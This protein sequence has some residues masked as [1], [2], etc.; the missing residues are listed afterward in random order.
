M[1]AGIGAGRA[2]E[3]N[4]HFLGRLLD[5]LGLRFA[6]FPER[7]LGIRNGSSIIVNQRMGKKQSTRWS[8]EGAHRLLQ[9]RCAVLDGQLASFFREWFPGFRENPGS[10]ERTM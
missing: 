4:P 6:A 7:A 2:L 9:V 10:F 8:A 3:R 1:A 5:G